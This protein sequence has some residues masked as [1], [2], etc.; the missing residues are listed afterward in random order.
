M[1]VLLLCGGRG[2]IEPVSRKRTPK[3]LVT[4]GDRPMLWHIMKSFATY[5]HKDFILALGE[6]S[7]DI[8]SYFLQYH[9]HSHDIELDLA[10][11]VPK[12]LNTTQEED[13][14]VKFVD[15]GLNAH[16]GSR[17]SRCA[18]Y[19]DDSLFLLSYSDCLCDVNINTLI[20]FHKQQGA[21]LT[22]TGVRPPS[23]FGTFYVQD[24]KVTG[25]SLEARLTGIGGYVNGGFMVVA[26]S[27][28]DYLEPYSECNLERD[29]FV[30]LV[31][32]GKVAVYQHDGYWQAVDTERD[33]LQLNSLYESNQRPW[34][35]SPGHLR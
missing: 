27:L 2:V 16:T 7:A 29:I 19:L 20:E 12:Q 14:T 10:H 23:R 30:R 3:G 22:V 31:Q 24:R 21:V 13:W 15:T 11:P 32:E 1:K 35:P 25:Y 18:R 26:K 8:R 4:I 5:G 33:L 17:I 34:L 6:G 9:L 28:F